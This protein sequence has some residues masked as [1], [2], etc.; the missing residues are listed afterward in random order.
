MAPASES[1]SDDSTTPLRQWPG[2]PERA[3]PARLEALCRLAESGEAVVPARA[4]NPLSTAQATLDAF[5]R[6]VV[7][8]ESYE[9]SV[10]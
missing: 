2:S 6:P 10:T 5:L 1:S 3:I 8:G 9:L 4:V 7:L